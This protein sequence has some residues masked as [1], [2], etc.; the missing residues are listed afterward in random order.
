MDVKRDFVAK[1]HVWEKVEIVLHAQ[2]SFTNAYTDVK[3]WVNLTGPGF[4]RR[5]YGFWDGG[6]TFRVRVLATVPGAWTWT[7]GS[8][9]ADPGLTGQKGSFD[10]IAW[11]ESEK[12]ANPCR[13]G[14]IRPSSNGHAFEYSDGTPFFLLGDTWWPTGTFRFRWRDDDTLRPIGPEAG[15]KEY[16]AFRKSQEFNCVTIVAAFPSWD[17]DDQSSHLKTT[18]G[19]ALRNG[20][21]QAGTSSTKKMTDEAGNRPFLFPGK[22]P[23]Y[24]KYFPDVERINPAYFQW[25]DRKID[26]LN[27]QGFVPF[28]EPARRDVGLA[29]KKYYPWPN[30]YSRFVEYIWSRYQANICLLSPLH[31]DNKA[32]TLPPDEWNRAFNAVIDEY[33]HPPFGTLAGNNSYISSLHLWGHVDKARWLGFHQIG[34]VYTHDNYDKLT[35][36][37]HTSPAVPGIN[38]ESYY[39]GML[40]QPSGSDEATLYCRSAMY[41]SVL[42][43]GLGGHIYGAGSIWC[44]EVE[45][46]SKLPMWKMFQAPSGD[47][48]RHMKAFILSEGVR[49][50]SL[51]PCL[52]LISPNRSGKAKG[53]TGWSYGAKTQQRDLFLLYFEKDCPQATL[54]GM[55]PNAKYQARW[56][57]PRTGV[58]LDGGGNGLLTS[59]ATGQAVLPGFPSESHASIEDWA[60]KLVSTDTPH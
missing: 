4:N 12:A 45:K 58:W 2:T 22:V 23:G 55:L 24:E 7:S 33:G 36:I 26:Y 1:V 28:I 5:C 35:E 52:E 29:W 41:G 34:N 56:F 40:Q 14:M 59:D 16:V 30:S 54:S 49:Y 31:F 51:I 10:A 38:G 17:N 44:G 21:K 50:Q 37:F 39:D 18:D 9:P 47:Q 20:W 48:M 46:E 6:D 43:G 57:N 15:F 19:M 8:E 53:M 13:R 25:L 27:S 11:S 42:S 60:L 3:V 32:T